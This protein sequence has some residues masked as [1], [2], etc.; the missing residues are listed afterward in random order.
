NKSIR[1]NEYENFYI[2]LNNENY[3]NIIENNNQDLFKTL[4]LKS[5]IYIFLQ[6][7]FPQVMQIRKI[8]KE[9]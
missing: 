5:R 4:D 6:A 7:Y 1:S 3:K 9:K 8:L 2:N